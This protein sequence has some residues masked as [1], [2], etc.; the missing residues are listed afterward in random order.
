M[1]A[2]RPDKR[3]RTTTMAVKVVREGQIR[4]TPDAGMG[5]GW[6]KGKKR[7]TG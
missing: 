3:Q 6:E 4:I 7:F 5:V 2:K 1:E